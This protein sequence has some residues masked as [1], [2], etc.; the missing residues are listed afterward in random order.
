MN[1][2]IP[3]L[4]RAKLFNKKIIVKNT[5]SKPFLALPFFGKEAK[6]NFSVN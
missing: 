5:D 3:K 4:F 1:Q 2:N 6:V